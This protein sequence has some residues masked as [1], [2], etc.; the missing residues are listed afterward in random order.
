MFQNRAPDPLGQKLPAPAV[1]IAELSPRVCFF[2]I[3]FCKNSQTPLFYSILIIVTGILSPDIKKLVEK[4]SRELSEIEG[5]LLGTSH[6]G[7]I[8]VFFITSCNASEGK[9]VTAISLAYA[10]SQNARRKVLLIDGNLHTPRL[11]EI[12]SLDAGPGL[13]DLCCGKVRDVERDTELQDLYV[14][15]HGSPVEN[16]ADLFRSEDFKTALDN[17]KKNFDYVIVDGCPVIGS[18]D[19]LVSAKCFDGIILV[20]ECEKTTWE[21]AETVQNKL[22]ISGGNIIG[23]VLNKRKYYIPRFLYGKI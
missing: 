11:H 2:E 21:I 22:K 17:L 18:S 12:F 9:T 3:I 10:L 4:N 23:A 6:D 20:V 13:T 1:I 7:Q 16:T 19:A 5:N 15:T 14:I 8:R